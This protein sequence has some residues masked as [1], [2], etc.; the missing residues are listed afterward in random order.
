MF[1]ARGRP[2]KS[3]NLK[4]LQ[5]NGAPRGLACAPA[6]IAW[7]VRVLSI[8]WS[9]GTKFQPGVRPVVSPYG[10]TGTRRSSRVV[11]LKRM[12]CVSI[13]IMCDL[14]RVSCELFILKR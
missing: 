11:A 7:N 14:A 2:R 12:K 5:T 1:G 8:K 6:R 9:Q 10:R 13:V 4:S 3:K